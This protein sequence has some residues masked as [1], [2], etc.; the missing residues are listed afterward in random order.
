MIAIA[1]RLATYDV[2]PEFSAK[3][4]RTFLSPLG[5]LLAA[6]A[7]ATLA[8]LVV[9]PRV[10][11]LA[12]GVLAVAAVGVCWPWLT[13]RAVRAAVRFDRPRTTEG[14]EVGV[15]ATVTN[16]LPWPA[17]GLT[18]TD[19]KAGA[20]V[21]LPAVRGRSACECRWVFA[22]LLR[23]IYPASVPTV[24]TGFPFGLW[25]SRRSAA[26]ESELIAWPRTYP[27]GPVPTTD[28]EDV[29]EGNV[30]RSKVGTTGDVL[31]VRPYRRGD[32]PRRIHWAQSARHDRLIVCELQSNSRPV[33][34]IVVDLDPAV[35]TAGSDG[36][37]EWAIRVAASLATGWL[38]DGA[39]VGL[40]AGDVSLPATAGAAQATRILDAL[41][42]VGDTGPSPA[43]VPGDRSTVTVVVT[44]DAAPAPPNRHADTR[45]VVLERAGFGG[46]PTQL[47]TGT[48]WLRLSSPAELPDQLRHGTGEASHGS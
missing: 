45:R 47:V 35:H 39:Q 18:V 24:R 34:R 21:R 4:R 26:V 33:V 22:P 37:R 12:G 42:R 43:A 19:D 11:A 17:W 1:R 20:S 30:T 38:A 48:P 6:G 15:T 25:H 44:T 7:V 46:D 29:V 14:G 10:F 41:A 32:S 8:G 2:S 40:T 5:V 16:P 3:V 36:T 28:G 23:G 9:H 31:G 27:V 13:A